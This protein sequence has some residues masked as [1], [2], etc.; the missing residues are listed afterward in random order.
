MMLCG[1]CGA[2]LTVTSRSHGRKRAYFYQCRAALARGSACTNSFPLP[3]ALTDG[4]MLGYLEGVLLHPDVV[5]EAIRR[6]LIPDPAAEVPE[7]HRARLQAEAARVDRELSNLA[8]AIA[9]GG[10]HVE[11]LVR[12]MKTRE[13]RRAELE[14]AV[15]SLA[16]VTTAPAIDP[17][18]LLPRIH[19]LLAGWRG[20]AVKH[21]QQTRQLLRKLLVG[22][23]RVTPDPA[24]GTVRLQGEGT[25][26]PLI[27]MLQL[28]ELQAVVAPTGFE[29]VLG[30]GHVFA[31]SLE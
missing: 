22:R 25:L 12:G 13:H 24:T 31:R 3:M 19:A 5:A 20:L 1:L 16:R 2:G 4:A 9:A 30:R 8:R 26:G 21:V 28:Q 23:L 14:H 11:T 15:T 6:T 7:A 29:P 27:G 17:A 18:H 10:G